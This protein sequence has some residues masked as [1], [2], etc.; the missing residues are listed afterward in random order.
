MLAMTSLVNLDMDSAFVLVGPGWR[1]FFF[2]LAR[3]FSS[4]LST[5]QI[6]DMKLQSCV[7]RAQLLACGNFKRRFYS[8]AD[9]LVGRSE[10]NGSWQHRSP[11]C[12]FSRS[13][14]QI[15]FEVSLHV[16]D[17]GVCGQRRR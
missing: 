12:F 17:R 11:L 9:F 16:K 3:E 13:G 15:L 1:Y 7:L 5:W 4:L 14:A 8:A 2:D 10:V 6:G